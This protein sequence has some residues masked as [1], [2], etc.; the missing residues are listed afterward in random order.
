LGFKKKLKKWGKKAKKFVRKVKKYIDQYGRV[1]DK[2]AVIGVNCPGKGLLYD[3]MDED[4][5]DMD[6]GVEL[7]Y[8]ERRLM[9]RRLPDVEAPRRLGF[10][11]KL[12]KW[13]KKAKKFVRKVKKYIDQYGKVCDKAAV[14]GVNCPGKGIIYD[15]MDDEEAGGFS[16]E[17]GYEKDGYNASIKYENDEMEDAPYRPWTR[18]SNWDE[19][20]DEGGLRRHEALT[21]FWDEFAD[22]E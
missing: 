17:A 14:I 20:D 11:K 4:L 8:A 10:K 16:V 3:E 18:D 5:Y 12:K 6:T 7:D 19:M 9:Q 1:C 15:E 21:Q 13:G 22:D 2:A